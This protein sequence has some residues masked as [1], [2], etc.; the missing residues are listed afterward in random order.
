[1]IGGCEGVRRKPNVISRRR[2]YAKGI[3]KGMKVINV[4]TSLSSLTIGRNEKQAK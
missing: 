1:V 2:Q 3:E 4:M